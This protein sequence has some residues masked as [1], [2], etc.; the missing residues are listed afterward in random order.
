MATKLSEAESFLHG[1]L[2]G[3]LESAC[4]SF[5]GAGLDCP[6]LCPKLVLSWLNC[7]QAMLACISVLL[8]CKVASSSVISAV[9]WPC[10]SCWPGLDVLN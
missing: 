6:A 1:G 4:L 5:T 7:P 8:C 3:G 10:C 2:D 9:F